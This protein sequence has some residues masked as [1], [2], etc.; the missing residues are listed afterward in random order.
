MIQGAIADV[1]SK[2]CKKTKSLLSSL[3]TMIAFTHT[4]NQP[5]PLNRSHQTEKGSHSETEA[6]PFG[7]G[8]KELP[9]EVAR[10]GSAALF[11]LG[12]PSGAERDRRRSICVLTEEEPLMSSSTASSSSRSFVSSSARTP[13]HITLCSRTKGQ[14]YQ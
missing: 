14:P 3:Q 1:L 7:H 12:H 2:S 6:P 5:S 4:S 13:S 8:P 11:Y 9:L 10:R